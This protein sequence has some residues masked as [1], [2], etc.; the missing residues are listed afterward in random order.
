MVH[1]HILLLVTAQLMF[2]NVLS[3]FYALS[4]IVILL[5]KLKINFKNITLAKK[6]VQVAAIRN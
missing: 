5:L 3:S 4:N 1:D 6:K 2:V